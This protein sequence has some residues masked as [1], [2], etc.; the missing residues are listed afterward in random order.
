MSSPASSL[1]ALA[2]TLPQPLQRFLARY[3]PASILPAGTDAAAA[4]TGYQQDRPN[5]FLYYK[6]PVTGKWNDPVYSLRRQAELVKM[7]REH[8]VEELLPEGPKATVNTLGKRVEHGLRVRGTGVGQ[9]VKGHAFERQLYNKIAKRREAMLAMPK[10]ITEWKKDKT[11]TLI[12]MS[13]PTYYEILGIS[14]AMLSNNDNPAHILKR[15]YRRALLQNHPD[16]AA[17]TFPS[18]STPT[19]PTTL[20]TIDQIS[21]AYKHLSTPSLKAAYDKALLLRPPS[22]HDP[23][24]SGIGQLARK[25]SFQTAETVDLDDLAFDETAAKW[26][27]GC[28][29]GNE[30]GFLFGEEDLEEAAD[31]VGELLVGCQD[32]SL[33]LKV[34]FTVVEEEE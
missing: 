15:A 26:F 24:V 1:V 21:T 7:A 5:P 6:H 2:K 3:P 22:H 10:L 13:L 9:K 29:C 11:P 8:G 23:C 4:K 18:S 28:R 20:F 33:W 34:F 17:A 16:K 25:G 14:K 27:R 19:T 31:D 30:R 32:C 12:S